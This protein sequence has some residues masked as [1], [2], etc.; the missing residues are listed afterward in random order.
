[1]V[2]KQYSRSIANKKKFS[3]DNSLNETSYR[4]FT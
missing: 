2:N 3:S 4:A 1:M